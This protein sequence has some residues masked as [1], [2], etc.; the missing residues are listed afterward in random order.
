MAITVTW[1]NRALTPKEKSIELPDH[2][3][4]IHTEWGGWYENDGIYLWWREY[5]NDKCKKLI[6]TKWK[7]DVAITV[8][9]QN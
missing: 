3:T 5:G 9:R 4:N 6:T 2:A 7:S 1:M 8:R